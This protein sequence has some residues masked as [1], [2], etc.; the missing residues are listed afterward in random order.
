MGKW[1]I[2]FAYLFFV[3]LPLLGLVCILRGDL[4][5]MLLRLQAIVVREGRQ[6]FLT[7]AFAMDAC[8]RCAP[9]AFNAVGQLEEEQREH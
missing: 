6:R 9:I 5:P 7:G 8:S 4:E 2:G 1:K 3:G